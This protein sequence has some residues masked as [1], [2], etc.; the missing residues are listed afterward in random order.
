MSYAFQA[1]WMYVIAGLGG[2]SHPTTT[3]RN[4]IVAAFMLYQLFY[5]VSLPLLLL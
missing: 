3:S 5:N 1:L 4:A 2:V